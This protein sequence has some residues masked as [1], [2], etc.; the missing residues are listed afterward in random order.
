MLRNETQTSEL[1]GFI[2]TMNATE[3]GHEIYRSEFQ[4]CLLGKQYQEQQQNI[5]QI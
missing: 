3:N 2:G 4:E 5:S 1:G